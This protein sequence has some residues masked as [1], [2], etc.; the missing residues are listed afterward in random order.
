MPERIGAEECGRLDLAREVIELLT[1]LEA[2]PTIRAWFA[3][4]NEILDDQAPAVR[5]ADRVDL[6]RM[7]AIDFFVDG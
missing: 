4:M 5:I 2:D 7:A 6:V 1:T 3:G